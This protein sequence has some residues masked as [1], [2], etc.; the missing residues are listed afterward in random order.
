M[1][2][3]SNFYTNRQTHSFNSNETFFVAHE[4]NPIFRINRKKYDN[5]K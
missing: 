1:N 2:E 3:I 5:N 4:L